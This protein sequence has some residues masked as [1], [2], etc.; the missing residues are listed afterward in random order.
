MGCKRRLVP[1]IENNADYY[2]RDDLDNASGQ[3]GIG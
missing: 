1:E 3:A 2:M